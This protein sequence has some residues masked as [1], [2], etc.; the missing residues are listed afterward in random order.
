MAVDHGADEPGSRSEAHGDNDLDSE[1]VETLTLGP[2]PSREGS[3]APR[4]DDHI[5]RV[6]QAKVQQRL[7]E[8]KADSASIGRFAVLELIGRGGMG[9][10]YA[11][12]DAQLDRKVAVKV[13]LDARASAEAQQRL[14]R[15]AQAMARLS[16]PNVVAVHEVGQSD[17]EVFVAMEFIRGQNLNEWIGTGP[18]WRQVLEVFIQAG[19]GLAAAHGAGLVHRDLK[20]HNIMRG[21]DGVVKVLDFGLARAAEGDPSQTREADELSSSSSMLESRLSHTGTL[22][23]TPAYM[24]PEQLRGAGADALSDQF[25]FCVAL[26]EALYGERPYD[27]RSTQA[28]RAAQDSTPPR[29]ELERSGEVRPPATG[30]KVPAAVRKILLRGLS[31]APGD[32]WP[33]MEELLEHLR[34]QL[35]PRRRSVLGPSLA[36]GLVGL[37]VGVGANQYVSW[38]ERCTGA[39]SQ[40]EGIWDEPRKTRVRAALL[41]T[42]LSYARETWPRVQQRLDEYAAAWVTA[43][44]EACEATSIRHEQSEGQLDLRMRCL[45]DHRQ[46]L[47][48]TVDELARGQT[49]VVEHAVEAVTSLPALSRCADLDALVAERPPPEDPAVARRVSALDEQLVEAEAKEVAGEYA[50][51]LAL[52]DT[53]V[54]EATALGY[55]PLLVRAWLQQGSLRKVTADYEGAVATLDQAYSAALAQRMT[56]EAASAS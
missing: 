50:E 36:V 16:H 51:A 23:G 56:A 9:R 35:A 48:A 24:A 41:E 29:A 45:Q 3:R 8:R 44:T 15:E 52:T 13:L 12:Y 14:Q 26:Y 39:A 49:S 43:H 46:H 42:E 33:G 18:Q 27:R 54:A 19:Q 38:S 11:A 6:I 47:R 17:G 2:R 5:Q 55:E 10:V 32:R 21:D 20:P 1:A 31:P 22:M 4:V 40:L 53:V 30:S 34:A 28:R 37:G 7:F 25:S